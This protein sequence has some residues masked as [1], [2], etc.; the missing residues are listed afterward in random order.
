MAWCGGF[1]DCWKEEFKRFTRGQSEM[2]FHFATG[3]VTHTF[4]MQCSG[5]SQVHKDIGQ[6]QPNLIW[7]LPNEIKHL[8]LVMTTMPEFTSCSSSLDN[9]SQGWW[10]LKDVKARA[11]FVL[12]CLFEKNQQNN[13]CCC[14]NPCLAP[15]PAPRQSSPSKSSASHTSDPAADDLFEEGFE[16]PSKSEEPEAVSSNK[17]SKSSLSPFS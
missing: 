9:D 6:M 4:L 8:G 10:K 11:N 3:Q 14:L 15:T 5:V 16:S 2:L 17:V 12:K 1:T 13:C 7:K